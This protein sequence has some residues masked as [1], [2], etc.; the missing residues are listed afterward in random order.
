MEVLALGDT[1]LPAD[2]P[3]LTA[4][5]RWLHVAPLLRSDFPAETLAFLARG[6]RLSFDGQGLVRAPRLG[7][8]Q[9]DADYDPEMLRDVWVL[10][11]S[12]E[13]ASRPRRLRG[14][15]GPEVVVT[16]GPAGATVYSADARR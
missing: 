2:V 4:G 11:L 5:V 1:W 3:A 12:E 9:L 14:A 15:A 13:E 16:R 7:P 6:R 10:K 8:L